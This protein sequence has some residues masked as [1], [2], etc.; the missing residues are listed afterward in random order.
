KP[1]GRCAGC[2]AFSEG[3]GMCLPKIPALIAHPQ[4]VARRACRRGVLSFGCFSLLRTSMCSALRAG[5]A[6]RAA[7]AAQWHKQ[8]KVTRAKARKHLLDIPGTESSPRLP[9]LRGPMKNKRALNRHA[10]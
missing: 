3:T 7:P 1:E 4:R 10:A 6:V 9:C 8:R 5:F 2:A